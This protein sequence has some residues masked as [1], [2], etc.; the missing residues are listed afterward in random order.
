[1]TKKT[2]ILCALALAS[3]RNPKQSETPE[4][5]IRDYPKIKKD[6]GV[7][8]ANETRY[9]MTD[10]AG[11]PFCQYSKPVNDKRATRGGVPLREGGRTVTPDIDMTD[12][13]N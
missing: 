10:A 5:Q 4:P 12:T 13:L 11:I 3:C 9:P 7:L 1:M 2:L 8:Y 6:T